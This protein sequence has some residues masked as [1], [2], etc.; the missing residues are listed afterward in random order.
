MAVFCITIVFY[1]SSKIFHAAG[2][3]VSASELA[4]IGA[5]CCNFGMAVLSIFIMNT[6]DRRTCILLSLASSMFFLVVL[7]VAILFIESYTWV[8][9][10]SII[11]VLGFV[12]CYG[13]GIGPIPYFI[14]SELFEVGPRPSA[15]ALGSMSNWAGNFLVGLLFPTMQDYI[16]PS[17]FFIFAVFLV[18][19][20]IFV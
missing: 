10:I 3:S 7:G 9:Y 5:G 8:P 16:G 2:L 4:T 6:F 18:A 17:S 15:M 11:G 13:L 12:I 1:Y 14:G 19:L 20:F